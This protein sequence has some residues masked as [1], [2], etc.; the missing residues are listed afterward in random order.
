MQQQ[1]LDFDSNA[2]FN[3][4][5][6]SNNPFG[7]DE[8]DANS[9]FEAKMLAKTDFEFELNGLELD[10][11]EDLVDL[12]DENDARLAI[13]LQYARDHVFYDKPSFF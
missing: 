3:Y 13:N 12:D 11:Q 8:S 1:A 2:S 10:K 4:L 9:E 7:S 5:G 6:R